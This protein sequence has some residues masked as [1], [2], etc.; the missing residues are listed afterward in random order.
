MKK[1]IK[2]TAILLTVSTLLYASLSATPEEEL[3][4]IAAL[5]KQLDTCKMQAQICPAITPQINL[6]AHAMV[7]CDNKS[8]EYHSTCKEIIGGFIKHAMMS[9]R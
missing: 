9:Q 2:L 5:F 6:I 1:I 7:K 8:N 4:R 3:Q